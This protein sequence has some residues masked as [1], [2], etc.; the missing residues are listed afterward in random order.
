MSSETNMNDL[1]D[2]KHLR[3]DKILKNWLN[4]SFIALIAA[5]ALSI[6]FT[7]TLVNAILEFPHVLNTL[8][9][10]TY[11]DYGDMWLDPSLQ[12]IEELKPLGFLCFA[13]VII[14]IIIGFLTKRVKIAFLSSVT[15]YLPIFG[16]FAV[17]M[18]AFAGIGILRVIWLPLFGSSIVP[19]EI[20]TLGD[21]V[22]LPFSISIYVIQLFLTE[23]LE[24]S[25]TRELLFD[26]KVGIGLLCLRL[27]FVIFLFS[28][29]NWLYAKFSRVEIIDFWLYKYSRHPQYVGLLLASY[30]MLIHI[31][32]LPYARGGYIP[33][34]SLLWLIMALLIV[35]ISLKEELTLFQEQ[36]EEYHAFRQKAPF[37]F[38]LPMRISDLFLFPAQKFLKK[39]WPESNKDIFILMSFYGVILIVSSLIYLPNLL[40]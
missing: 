3:E 21:I 4:K 14:G 25:V 18:F 35:S 9:I 6:L 26:F 1:E 36:P 29:F 28:S 34:P 5:M 7:I 16:Y 19:W 12:V 23:F 30:G 37:L 38:P 11:P 8:L 13:L 40:A 10:E 31:N 15:I 24:V 33:A 22:L 20:L 32:F 27:G 2:S 17:S 39:D